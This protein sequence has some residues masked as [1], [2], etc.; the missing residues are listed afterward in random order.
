MRVEAS[1]L[2]AK[3]KQYYEGAGSGDPVRIDLPRGGYVPVFHSGGLRRSPAGAVPA[4]GSQAAP[5]DDWR[6]RGCV[7]ALLSFAAAGRCLRT[8]A[9]TLTLAI[10]PLANLTGDPETARFAAA[11]TMPSSTTDWRRWTDFR[12]DRSPAR[13]GPVAGRGRTQGDRTRVLLRLVR[14][15]DGYEAWTAFD[16]LPG[17]ESRFADLLCELAA[18][19]ICGSSLPGIRNA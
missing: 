17:E 9:D 13:A 15:G 5:G 12:S 8:S 19:S 7:L 16:S 18:R 1:R 3:L 2:R 14:A 6:G 4:V 11:A 10:D